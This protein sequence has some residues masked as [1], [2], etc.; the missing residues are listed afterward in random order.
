MAVHPR[1]SQISC[2]LAL[3]LLEIVYLPKGRVARIFLVDDSAASRTILRASLEQDGHRVEEFASAGAASEAVPTRYPDLIITDLWMPGLSGVQFCR[4]LRSEPETAQIPVFLVTASEDRRSR[5]WAHHA[6]ATA[7]FNKGDTVRLLRSI[8]ERAL[9]R[10]SAQTIPPPVHHRDGVAERI[11]HLLD[12]LLLESTVTAQ[13]RALAH[14]AEEPRSLFVALA[15]LASSLVPYRWMALRIAGEERL[16]LHAHPGLFDAAER[17][18]QEAFGKAPPSERRKTGVAPLYSLAD[19]RPLNQTRAP[20]PTLQEIRFGSDVVGTLAFSFAIRGVDR[21]DLRI[22]ALLADEL[23]GVLRMSMLVAEAQRL[24]ATDTLTNLLNRRGL[25]SEY[26]HCKQRSGP[27]SLLLLDVDH[28]KKVNDELGH[29]AGDMVLHSVANLLA[30]LA[31]AT[32][33]VARW[34]GEEFVVLLPGTSEA[35]A[36][37]AAERVRRAIAD[38]EFALAAGPPLRKTVSVGLAFVPDAH[39]TELDELVARADKAMY[40]AKSRGRNRVEVG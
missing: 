16:H 4:L 22:I 24:A 12:T 31:R 17:E 25:A 23:G 10:E 28:F 9:T 37:V 14:F 34:G 26:V 20:A 8:N 27:V 6:G 7:Y 2:Q 32:D 5:F 38:H 3:D 36:R 30:K 19:D 21:E 40:L 15:D 1:T 35:G 18:M 11:S 39:D 33:V 29:E 13:A